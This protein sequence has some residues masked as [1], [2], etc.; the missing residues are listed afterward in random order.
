MS[1][2]RRGQVIIHKY[3][4]YYLPLSPTPLRLP[5]LGGVREENCFTDIS[6]LATL[7]A[8]QLRYNKYRY[9]PLPLVGACAPPTLRGQ[10]SQEAKPEVNKV[11][12]PPYG[13]M[14]RYLNF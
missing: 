2:P 14:I 6:L 9:T 7:V 13:A 4:Y 1:I 11:E 5:T 10:G 12:F 3:G 8:S